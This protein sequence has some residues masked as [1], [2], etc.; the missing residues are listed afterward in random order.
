MRREQYY[1]GKMSGKPCSN[2]MLRMEQFCRRFFHTSSD[3][4]ICLAGEIP[5]LSE[6]EDGLLSLA[7]LWNDNFS[8]TCGLGFY[9]SY[10]GY[11]GA[12]MCSH[13]DETL[14]RLVECVNCNIWRSTRKRGIQ[15]PV[16]TGRYST[17]T[18]S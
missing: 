12:D 6:L 17:S 9:F 14:H 13:W 16:R 11:W 15:C 18:N 5:E 1:A 8:G 4:V 10:Q 7:K 2:I 3:G